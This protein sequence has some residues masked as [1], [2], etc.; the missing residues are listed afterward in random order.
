MGDERVNPKRQLSNKMN[1][2]SS[3]ITGKKM[4][5][6]QFVELMSCCFFY[7][8][9]L[10]WRWL[11]SSGGNIFHFQVVSCR[12]EIP[13]LLFF[14]FLNLFTILFE[15]TI[16]WVFLLSAID[17]SCFSDYFGCFFL[18]FF[19]KIL[20]DFWSRVN[21]KSIRRWLNRHLT[22]DSVLWL[23]IFV[24]IN[25]LTSIKTGI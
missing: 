25:Q 1:I 9:L 24:L 12:I 19:F 8:I 3:F 21:W 16:F 5:F 20:W 11:S 10:M 14:P 22:N 18:F 23:D 17:F 4:I 13:F 7:E 15:S 2:F 6:F